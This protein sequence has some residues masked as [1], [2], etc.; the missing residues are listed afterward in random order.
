MES[1]TIGTNARLEVIGEKA[2]YGAG[3]ETVSI[4]KST[5]VIGKSAFENAKVKNLLF[6]E[7]SSLFQICES[8]F[9]STLV[10]VIN[11]PDGLSEIHSYAFRNNLSLTRVVLP[12]S[13][14]YMGESVFYDCAFEGVY[15]RGV[16]EDFKRNLFDR[17]WDL[18]HA[19][20]FRA[21]FYSETDNGK[22]GQWYYHNGVPV[23]YVKNQ[24]IT[25]DFS[26]S[27]LNIEGKKIVLLGY[28]A[29]TGYVTECTSL[30]LTQVSAGVYTTYT[31]VYNF[32]HLLVAVFDEE[33]EGS[34]LDV[35]EA[36]YKTNLFDSVVNHILITG[37]SSTNSKLLTMV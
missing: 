26:G 4:P 30:L 27:G 36:E 15:V 10:E 8:A 5:E 1:L 19:F 28:S 14:T 34:I 32:K 37:V 35:T 6:S 17:D 9:A 20:R 33:Y 13:L 22:P 12:T 25:L 2:F 16:E 7:N 21:Y 3:V 23:K 11:I 24:L 29:G 31:N 18:T